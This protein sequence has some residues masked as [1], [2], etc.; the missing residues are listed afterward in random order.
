MLWILCSAALAG[1]ADELLTKVDEA[2]TRAADAHVILHLQTTDKKGRPVE[3]TIE[4]W[5]KGDDKRLVRFS[6]PAR[7][8]GTAMLVPDGDTIYLYLPAYGRARRI[9][10]EARGDAFVGT[11][12]AMEDLAAT[13]FSEE[14]KPEQTADN[15]LSLTPLPDKKT[16]SA[17][18]ELTVRPGDHLPERIV[19][20]D[21]DGQRLRELTFAEVRDI[22]GIPLAHSISVE[23]M[24]SGRTTRATVSSAEF[25]RGLE[26]TLFTIT[27]LQR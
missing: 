9:V 4:T 13:R 26:D 1:P 19:H 5:Q 24:E 16:S 15:V 20:F 2:V 25:D 14:W 7:L 18:I 22:D 6:E 10:G 3:R 11:D 8:A 17:R 23:N 12:F 21:K 27:N